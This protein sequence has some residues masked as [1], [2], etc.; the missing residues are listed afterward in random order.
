LIAASAYAVLGVG[1]TVFDPTMYAQQTLMF[2]EQT[3]Q[4]EEE[5]DRTIWFYQ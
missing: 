4:V 1:D 2:E 5:T 3:Q